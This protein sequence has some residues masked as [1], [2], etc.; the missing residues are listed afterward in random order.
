M[1]KNEANDSAVAVE[2][3]TNTETKPTKKHNVAPFKQLHTEECSEE[4][5]S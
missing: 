3:K 4:E 2:G 1:G 5:Q